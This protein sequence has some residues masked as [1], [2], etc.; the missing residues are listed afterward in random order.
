MPHASGLFPAVPNS[1]STIPPLDQQRPVARV[2]RITELISAG[3]P[4]RQ[5][6]DELVNMVES[7]SP[8][9][10]LG[11]ILLLAEDGRLRHGS[12]PSLPDGYNAAIDGLEIGPSVGSCGTAAFHDKTV[13]VYDIAND[14]LWTNFRDLALQHGLRAC[15]STPI[16][17]SDGKVIGTFANYYPV[18]RDPSPIDRELTDMVTRTAARA[19]EQSRKK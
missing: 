8:A 15:W 10:M 13:V 6:L 2:Q 19:I 1:V 4:L 9:G 11:S 14:R 17:G 16:H 12:A 18:V 5:T 3:A 7:L